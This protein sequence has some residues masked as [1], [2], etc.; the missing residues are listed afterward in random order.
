M[1]IKVTIPAVR[2]MK[3]GRITIDKATRE[4]YG[5]VEGTMWKLTLEKLSK[6]EN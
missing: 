5:I 3:D 2:I 1:T 6:T 4:A